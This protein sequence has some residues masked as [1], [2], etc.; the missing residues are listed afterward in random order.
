MGCSSEVGKKGEKWDKEVS[1]VSA[2]GDRGKKGTMLVEDG[3]LGYSEAR[4]PEEVG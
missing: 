2:Q 1:G 4:T 3:C